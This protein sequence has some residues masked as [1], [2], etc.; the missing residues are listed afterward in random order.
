MV[1][2]IDATGCVLIVVLLQ[3][4]DKTEAGKKEKREKQRKEKK[5]A[6]K[7]KKKEKLASD[8]SFYGPGRSFLSFLFFFLGFV[9]CKSFEN[10]TTLRDFRRLERETKW[11]L[12]HK[13][14]SLSLSFFLHSLC[15]CCQNSRPLSV[16]SSQAIRT[17]NELPLNLIA[18][19]TVCHRQMQ[20]FGWERER[21][22]GK[23]SCPYLP[24]T[25]TH[26]RTVLFLI[27]LCKPNMERVEEEAFKSSWCI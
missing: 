5:T 25:H 14:F 19:E 6:Q 27:C 24:Y 4:K 9:L 10:M 21:E 26:T 13:S 20:L 7:N 12:L 17:L 3:Q 18:V 22:G 15:N 23:F 8:S 16:H 1:R 11:V 2:F